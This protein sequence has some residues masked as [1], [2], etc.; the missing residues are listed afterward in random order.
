[1]TPSRDPLSTS[2]TAGGRLR[3][4]AREVSRTA[5]RDLARPLLWRI[6]AE[7]AHHGTVV[8]AQVLGARSVGRA[9]TVLGGYAVGP[10]PVGQEPVELLGGVHFPRVGEL[11]YLLTLGG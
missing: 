6:D 5:Y 4:A 8:A 7:S 3:R 9:L 2:N 10:E 1:M 11:P